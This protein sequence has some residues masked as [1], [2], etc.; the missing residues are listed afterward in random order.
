M[1]RWLGIGAVGAVSAALLAC[2][3]A[4][5]LDR[6]SPSLDGRAGISSGSLSMEPRP[7]VTVNVRVFDTASPVA[8][9]VLF[10]GGSGKLEQ[11]TNT[12]GYPG[13]LAGNAERFAAHGLIAALVDAPSDQRGADGMSPQ[14][15]AGPDHAADIDAVIARLKLGA[16]LPV[17]VI[18][19]SQGTI[20]AANAAVNG[21]HPI[22]G[23]VLASSSM[24]ITR[25]KLARV[26]APALLV[27]H[28]DDG[29]PGTPPQGAR[30]IAQALTGAPVAEVEFFSGGETEGPNPCHPGT[31]HTFHGIQDSVVAFIAEFIKAH[32]N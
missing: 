6:P 3:P 21:R 15:R 2:Q 24:T 19:V 5:F 28:E 8:I 32:S 1:T 11:H 27:A 30:R 22:D 16:D 10:M 26:T 18:G 20:S 31:P 25:M 23:V 17:W 29:C 7:G 12:R 4:L 14:F 13:F 9:A